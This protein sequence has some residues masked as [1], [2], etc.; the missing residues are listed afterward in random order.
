MMRSENLRNY[1]ITLLDP[2]LGYIG[3]VAGYGHIEI[4]TYCIIN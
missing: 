3:S 4:V 1:N 2:R